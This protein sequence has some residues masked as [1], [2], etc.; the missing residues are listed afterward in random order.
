MNAPP[1]N[2]GGC[3]E[4]GASDTQP[5]KVKYGDKKAKTFDLCE[6]CLNDFRAADLIDEMSLLDESDS[7]STE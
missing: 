5:L 6:S 2:D 3:V 1:D 7:D 4:C